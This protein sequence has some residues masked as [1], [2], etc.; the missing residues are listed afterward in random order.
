MAK[1]KTKTKPK[2]QTQSQRQYQQYQNVYV[3][4]GDYKE[5][6]KQ[7]KIRNRKTMRTVEKSISSPL[8]QSWNFNAT[9]DKREIETLR[10]ELNE[11]KNKLIGFQP[12]KNEVGIQQPRNKGWIRNDGIGEFPTI[13]SNPQDVKKIEELNQQKHNLQTKLDNYIEFEKEHSGLQKLDENNKK[14]QE[15]LTKLGSKLNN[16][17]QKTN[18]INNMSTNRTCAEKSRTS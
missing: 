3:N 5:K 4:L 2:R 9:P 18:L 7:K 8:P 15:T 16:E 1:K 14:K 17:K 13:K 12:Y 6:T 10:G 11:T